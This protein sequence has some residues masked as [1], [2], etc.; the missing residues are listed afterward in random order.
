MTELTDKLETVIQQAA[1]DGAL[2]KDAV[3]QFHSLVKE[4]DA[5][6]DANVEW[7]EADEKNKKE[8]RKLVSELEISKA[9]NK[10]AME[11]EML[12]IER[13][14]KMT[15]LELTAAHQSKRVEDHVKMVELIFRNSI[16]RREVMTPASQHTE[17]T[18]ASHS[19]FSN[20]DV[21]DEKTE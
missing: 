1:L 16:I 17:A 11:A 12:M 5:L 15:T 13:E 9:L 4:R 14:Q 20:K 10:V 8:V 6:K 21:V 3:A 2:T 18:G 19:T 7:E